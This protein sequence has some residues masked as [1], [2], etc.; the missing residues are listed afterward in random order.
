MG[1]NALGVPV[2][3]TGGPHEDGSHTCGVAG[4]DVL[5]LLVDELAH[6]VV[7]M[8]SQRRI[9]HASRLAR[10]ELAAGGVFG[11]L[12]GMLE[13]LAPADDK[14]F[15]LAVD[16]AATGGRGLAHLSSQKTDFLVAVTPLAPTRAPNLAHDRSPAPAAGQALA[17]FFPRPSVGTSGFF[18]AFASRHGLTGTEQ[19]V[20]MML[21]R[22]LHTPDIAVEMRVAVSTVRSHV[23]S[24]C[25]KT[26]SSGVRALLNRLALLPPLAPAPIGS[27]QP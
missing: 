26:G 23:R 16:Q 25:V 7:I 20:L 6:G 10:H 1:C 9:L 14:A 22:C 24:L 27:R 17:V 15:Q 4:P 19:Q 18:A 2:A 13:A 5:S 11:N 8:D 21:C 3:G 12:E